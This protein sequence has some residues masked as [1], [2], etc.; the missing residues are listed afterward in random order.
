[1]VPGLFVKSPFSRVIRADLRVMSR[2]K[3]PFFNFS[4]VI[5][6]SFSSFLL[7]LSDSPGRGV[8]YNPER[9]LEILTWHS[10]WRVCREPIAI[11]YHVSRLSFHGPPRNHYPPNG[12][13]RPLLLDIAFR[14][15]LSSFS[16]TDLQL[17]NL[18]QVGSYMKLL[19]CFWS[20]GRRRR[21]FYKEA[22]FCSWSDR[23][24][25]NS[26]V[27]AW[28]LSIV[29]FK[30]LA[31]FYGGGYQSVTT[32]LTGAVTS[33]CNKVTAADC[34]VTWGKRLLCVFFWPRYHN[35]K[36]GLYWFSVNCLVVLILQLNLFW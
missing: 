16:L 10:T 4:Q 17:S 35:Q 19:K 1:M 36:F 2:R 22:N 18:T 32:C 30:S 34:R 15:C 5:S 3:W 27:L 20:V 28:N 31:E 23:T 33:S 7:F 8:L 6:S 21:A 29:W 26:I 14:G 12:S 24:R 13:A 11:G 9:L 25:L